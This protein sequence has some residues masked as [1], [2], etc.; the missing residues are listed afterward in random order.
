MDDCVCSK[1]FVVSK[2]LLGTKGV[3][4]RCEN[5]G[6]MSQSLVADLVV[7]LPRFQQLL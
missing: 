6:A 2:L 1:I 3:S 4:G 7:A 5:G